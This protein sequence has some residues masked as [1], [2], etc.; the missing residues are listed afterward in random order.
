MKLY[1]INATPVRKDDSHE[2]TVGL[3]AG[4]PGDVAE[5]L[6][7][8]GIDGFTMYQVNG[9]WQGVP[10]VSFKIELA[11]LEDEAS[12]DILDAREL[13]RCISE[14]LRNTYNQDS[15]MVTLP[16]NTVEFI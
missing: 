5:L 6:H 2:R 13:V 14:E 1:T 8:Y 15:V 9:Y 3:L 10:E 16:D 11:L 12:Y 7:E 4:Y